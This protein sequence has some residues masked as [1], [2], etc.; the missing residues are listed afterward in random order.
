MKSNAFAVQER[1]EQ[2]GPAVEPENEALIKQILGEG[3]QAAG[4]ALARAV[5]NQRAALNPVQRLIIEA[6]FSSKRPPIS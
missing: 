5:L 4:F 3:L 2:D 6:A 1:D